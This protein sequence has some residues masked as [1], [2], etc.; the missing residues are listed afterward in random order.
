MT[1]LLTAVHRRRD[2]VVFWVALAFLV[3]FAIDDLAAWWRGAPPVTTA[4]EGK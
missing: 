1:R 3:G 2:A 4:Q